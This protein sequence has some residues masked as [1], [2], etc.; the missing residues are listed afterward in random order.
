MITFTIYGQ[1]MPTCWPIRFGA[2][3]KRPSPSREPPFRVHDPGA[4]SPGAFS[5]IVQP[6][7]AGRT[8]R[9][10]KSN[11]IF[12]TSLVDASPSTGTDRSYAVRRH[13]YC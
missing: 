2:G 11:A 6:M 10:G 12:I 1:G 7:R 8:M 4:D 13:R 9:M 3:R 5:S